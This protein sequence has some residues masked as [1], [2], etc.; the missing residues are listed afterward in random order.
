M[1]QMGMACGK[2]ATSFNNLALGDHQYFCFSRPDRDAQD[3]QASLDRQ[4]SCT[5]LAYHEHQNHF[6]TILIITIVIIGIVTF[7][8]KCAAQSELAAYKEAT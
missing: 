5:H 1:S 7:I 3:R 2:P 6:I 4:E 8:S